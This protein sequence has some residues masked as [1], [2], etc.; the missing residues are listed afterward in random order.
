MPRFFVKF[1]VFLGLLLFLPAIFVQP[2]AADTSLNTDS[3]S[4]GQVVARGSQVQEGNSNGC[5]FGSINGWTAINQKESKSID[6][7]VD[8]QCNLSVHSKTVTS[9]QNSPGDPVA[10][11]L[12]Y[13]H[14][15]IYLPLTNARGTATYSICGSN[16]CISNYQ[17]NCWFFPDGWAYSSCPGVADT[18]TGNPT[19][20]YGHGDF[21]WTGNSYQHTLSNSENISVSGT[22][23]TL[24]CY[25]SWSGTIV[26][27]GGVLESCYFS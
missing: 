20:S 14:D 17:E 15:V 19:H 6:L 13:M 8:D 7:V 18:A 3:L 10:N 16:I 22:V 21:H 11:N 26:P 2:V 24:V 27:Y 1:S 5:D 4:V 23:V 25:W 9:H 12:V